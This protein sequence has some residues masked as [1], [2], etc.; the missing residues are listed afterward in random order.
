MALPTAQLGQM[1]TLQMPF[2]IPVTPYEKHPKA[3]QQALISIMAQTGANALGKG[4]ENYMQP[5][6]APQPATGMDK[7]LHGPMI[8]QQR[9]GELERQGLEQQ[10]IDNAARNARLNRIL[11]ATSQNRAR[12]GQMAQQT[13]DVNRAA[14]DLQ[15]GGESRDIESAIAQNTAA[16]QRVQDLIAQINAERERQLAQQQ[17]ALLGAQTKNIGAEAAQ[18]TL[19]NRMMLDSMNALRAKGGLPPIDEQGYATQSAPSTLPGLPGKG[20]SAFNAPNT[21][22]IPTPSDADRI[23][24]ALASGQSPDQVLAQE[25]EVLRRQNAVQQRLGSGQ[26]PTYDQI[27]GPQQDAASAILQRINAQKTLMSAPDLSQIF[28]QGQ[29]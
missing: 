7:F 24:A 1:P 28:G 18:H 29:F 17:G 12:A 6:Y 11:E 8:S 16:H 4:V 14:Q 5:D 23:G 27:F 10:Q 25:Q 2:Y 26:Y 19:Q 21:S 9:A 20:T 22:T 3:W 13:I 15:L